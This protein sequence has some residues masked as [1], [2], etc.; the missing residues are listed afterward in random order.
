M[1]FHN[2]TVHIKSV[3]NKGQ[4]YDYYDTFLEQSSNQFSKNCNDTFI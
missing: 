1:T 4:N 3:W 2:I